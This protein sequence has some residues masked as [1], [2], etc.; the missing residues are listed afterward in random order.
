M[1]KPSNVPAHDT[2][3]QE[4][5]TDLDLRPSSDEAERPIGLLDRFVRSRL[6]LFL[7]L[8]A[9]ILALKWPTLTEP[10]LWDAAM[11]VFPAAITLEEHSFDYGYL[12]SQPG[13]SDGGPM[14]IASHRSHC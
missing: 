9:I 2:A 1:P 14:S 3:Q 10:P 12:L 7:G 13:Y 5:M 4:P 8:F 11:S 6:A